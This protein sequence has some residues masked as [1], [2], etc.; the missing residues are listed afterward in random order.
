MGAG[1]ETTGPSRADLT[2]QHIEERGVLSED[3]VQADHLAAQFGVDGVDERGQILSCVATWS[4]QVGHD[5]GSAPALTP[6]VE[7]CF[8]QVRHRQF[9]E[10]WLDTAP[11][12]SGELA[13]DVSVPLIRLGG[14]ASVCEQDDGL[15]LG[16]RCGLGRAVDP[17][18]QLHTFARAVGGLVGGIVVHRDNL[19]T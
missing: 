6:E 14:A 1:W 3:R 16:A 9:E 11:G 17:R 5:H 7:R 19:R 8:A 4:Q 2:R 12:T 10:G 13:T 15:G 18:L